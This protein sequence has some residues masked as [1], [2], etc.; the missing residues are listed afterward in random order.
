MVF[1]VTKDSNGEFSNL[2]S[3]EAKLLKAAERTHNLTSFL[4]DNK[5]RKI[6]YKTRRLIAQLKLR[7]TDHPLINNLFRKLESTEDELKEKGLYDLDEIKKQIR[8]EQ[9][10]NNQEDENLR[11]ERYLEKFKKK[12]Y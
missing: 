8:Q 9:K 3:N 1:E 2:H 11:L 12:K 4:D 6:C 10:I 7:K 5:K